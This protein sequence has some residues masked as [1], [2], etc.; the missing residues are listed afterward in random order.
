MAADRLPD[1]ELLGS[2]AI[3][4]GSQLGETYGDDL[5]ARV[6][7]T[8]VLVGVAAEDPE[9]DLAD[10]LGPEA[11]AAAAVIEEGCVGDIIPTMAAVAGTPDYF[12]TDP[13]TAPVGTA[14]L[15]VNDPGQVASES[16]LLLVQ[17]GQDSL[18]LP[19]RTAALLERLCDLGQ[20]VDTLDVPAAD[21]D[22]V[23]DLAGDDIAPWV[24]AR[25][26][27]EPAPDDC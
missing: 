19:A 14:W 9:V 22:T 18:V 12:V 16:P 20:V 4:P 11:P 15:E 13:R 27:G 1:A 25:F 6:I 21:H 3:A 2:V 5:Q 26:A 10:Y 8:M 24:A 17:G 7:T 23:T